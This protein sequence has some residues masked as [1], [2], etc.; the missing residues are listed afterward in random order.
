MISPLFER[1]WKVMVDPKGGPEWGAGALGAL[2]VLV[3]RYYPYVGEVEA[4]RAGMPATWSPGGPG[5]DH[6]LPSAQ[7]NNG[8]G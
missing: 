4:N 3:G 7:R 6:N 1:E 2:L 5:E 8:I